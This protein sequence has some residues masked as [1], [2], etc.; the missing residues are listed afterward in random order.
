[1]LGMMQQKVKNEGKQEED[2]F[3][4]FM[5]YCKTGVTDLETSISDAEKKLPQVISALEEAGSL[6][7]QIQAEIKQHKADKGEAEDAIAKATAL[8]EKEASVFAKEKADYD[9]NIAAVGKAITAVSQGMKGG[10][11][12]QT[13]AAKK[14]QKLVIDMKMSDMDRD[15]MSSFLSVSE[16]EDYAPASGQIVG[17]LKQ[18]QDTMVADLADMTKTEEAAKASFKELLAAKQQEIDTNQKALES[19]LKREGELGVEIEDLKADN[20]DTVKNLGE[21]KK[22]L[23]DLKKGCA[24]KQ[25]EHDENVKTRNAELLCISDTIKL[26]NDDDA[27]ELF[28]KT[29]PAPTLMQVQVTAKQMKTMALKA[30]GKSQ[31]HDPRID[32]IALTL[33]GHTKGFEK[34]LKMIDNMVT[35]LGEE[36]VTD[37]EK[38]EYC[39]DELDKTEDELKELEATI[40]DLNAAIKDAKNMI[41]KTTKEIADLT[42]T[43]LDLDKKVDEQTD[44]RKKE[45]A[46]YEELIASDTAAK[47]LLKMAK[48]RMAKFYAPKLY[49]PPA[50]EELSAAGRIEANMEGSASLVQVRMHTNAKDDAAPPPPP[51]TVGAY[52]KKTEESNG[53]MQ[54]MDMLIA[55]LDK[56]MTEGKTEEDNSQEEYEEFM[57]DAK[58]KKA[59]SAKSVEDKRAA[60]AD[61]EGKLE[62]MDLEK[63]GTVKT[64]YGKTE[65]LGDLHGECDWLLQNYDSRKAAR[66]GEIESLKNAKAVLSGAD[67][68]L[69]QTG[70][71]SLRGRTM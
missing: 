50:K 41:E 33:K 4:K 43:I 7:E 66:T 54:M 62:K 68:S 30:L 23:A 35:L 17:I 25:G 45:N 36:Q 5:C 20:G 44:I 2:L 47:E 27:L 63:K 55:D 67:F 21:D 57:A 22:F 6:K 11:F 46:E 59:S 53:V 56:E 24:T 31:T 8:R 69:V 42:A 12:L 51:E 70:R 9:S 34:V 58:E 71:S 28:K 32:L 13:R 19:K 39:E 10:A 29:L 65:E 16:G 52:K 60:K 1:M 3:E 48:N 15:A 37:D 18:M 49:K 14:L 64:A 38:K 26:L 61:M 40:K